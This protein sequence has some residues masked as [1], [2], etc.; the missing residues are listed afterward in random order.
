MNDF[1]S[2]SRRQTVDEWQLTPSDDIRDC[3][4]TV[5]EWELVLHPVETRSDYT[6]A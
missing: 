6:A 1:A 4:L 5:S 2:H 3:Q